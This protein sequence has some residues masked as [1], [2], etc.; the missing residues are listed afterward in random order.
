MT[1]LRPAFVVAVALLALA[2]VAAPPLHAQTP[3]APSVTVD[4]TFAPPTGIA[5]D[6]VA[7]KGDL[8]SGTAVDGDRIY[9]VGES[10][11]SVVIVARRSSG[12]LDSG[13]A[14]DGRL[15]ISLSPDKDTG[16]AIVV[17][18]D[19]RLRVLA[20]TDVL[21]STATNVDVALIGLN[22]DGT[23]DQ[24]FGGGDGRVTFPVGTAEDT[25]TKMV[26]D[27]TGRLAV[28]G[29]RKDANGKED[30]FVAMREPDGSPTPAFGQSAPSDLDGLRVFDR[31]GN[32][33]NDRATDIAF[34]P[35]GGL[36]LLLQVATSADAAVNNY[37]SVLHAV[38]EAGADD[39]A[40]SDDGDMVLAVGDPNTQVTSGALLLY[41]GR[42]WVT[43]A[44]KV[45][46][47][48]DAYLARVELDGSGLQ[49]RRFDMRGGRIAATEPILSSGIDLT[50]LPGSP[51][52][53]V[54]VG[55]ITYQSRPYWA[56]A[57][58]N[59]LSAS[60]S[61]LGF[62]DVLIVLGDNEHGALVGVAAGPGWLA[63]AG[64]IVD[65]S[66]FVDTSFGTTKLLIDAEKRCDLAVEVREPLEVRFEGT[67][68]AGLNIRVTNVGTK[69]CAGTISVPAPYAL[70]L[71][72]RTGALPTGVLAPG[73]SYSTGPVTLTYSGP[74]RRD[75]TLGV[76]VRSSA[77]TNAENDFS[78]IGVVFSY[79]DLRLAPAGS[80]RL[81]PD[82]GSRS[83]EFSLRN[84]GTTPCRR[85]RL[86]AG[87]GVRRRGSTDP[88]TLEGGRSAS[89]EISAAP[90]GP[91]RIGRRVRMVFRALADA[92]VDSRNDSA[93][94][95]PMVIGVG[96]TNARRPGSRARR[97]SGR[98]SGG[99]GPVSRRSRR[100]T[101]VHVAVRKIGG[102]CR[103]LGSKSGRLRR[104]SGRR[105]NRPVWLRAAG[106][107]RWALA[108]EGSLPRGRYL[109]YS[110]ATIAA[111]GFREASFS[112][113]D[114][115][116]IPFT[117]R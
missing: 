113:R 21:T 49:F 17:L 63:A 66:N 116:R 74:R 26:A 87:A 105:C 38:T 75:D 45:G 4:P 51:D 34:K 11:N 61:Q 86:G 92:D 23:D 107:T 79:C 25:P 93:V 20:S 98:A 59:N 32:N 70:R 37:V 43:G 111:G 78:L 62:D 64:S 9:T 56:A 103:W 91:R 46:T 89:E 77:D 7:S 44:A 14:G 67:K 36:L 69:A 85:S 114:R 42:W 27:A 112:S 76:R 50:L 81:V 5:V 101:R 41:G 53:L 2:T 90:A 97:L 80:T 29:L 6:D 82:E 108:L 28:A 104:G 102:R 31:A 16:V 33:L 39:N 48:T 47:D 65:F 106:T 54:V 100:V 72:A 83:F 84:E 10:D 3:L 96:D 55:S 115:N 88:F 13:F 1:R 109:L 19:H 71:G 110:R 73:A 60:V 12:A 95:S 68:P 15:D 30:T 117:I 8:A 52:T 22:S 57:A 94:L 40:F 99:R 24:T 18:P 35:G 58:F